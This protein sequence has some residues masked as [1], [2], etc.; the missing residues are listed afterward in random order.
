MIW[1][2][3]P[4]CTSKTEISD[5]ET[6]LILD[7]WPIDSGRIF[8]SLSRASDDNDWMDLKSTFA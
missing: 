7:A 2:Y 4:K 1:I 3:R 6:P 8:D 5:G